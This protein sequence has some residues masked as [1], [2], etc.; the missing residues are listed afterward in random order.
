MEVHEAAADLCS[1]ELDSVSAQSGLANVMNVEIQ[2]P[3]THHGQDHTE[4]MF[5]LIGI[6]QVHLRGGRRSTAVNKKSKYTRERNSCTPTAP[7]AG[8]VLFQKE[9]FL[10]LF[11]YISS[12]LIGICSFMCCCQK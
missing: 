3:A 11:F 2:V 9:L 4:G 7:T 10:Y 8:K 1:V 6:R 12:G 5:G